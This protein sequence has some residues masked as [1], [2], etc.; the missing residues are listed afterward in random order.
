MKLLAVFSFFI[1]LAYAD[2]AAARRPDSRMFSCADATAI[3]QQNGAVIYQYGQDLYHR[4][5]ANESFCL[6]DER[7]LPLHL[8]TLDQA[9]CFVGFV[10]T[11][12]VGQ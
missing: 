12:N 7:A 11:N 3:V 2:P 9:S 10:C 8:P 6:Q 1:L 4:A 5:V